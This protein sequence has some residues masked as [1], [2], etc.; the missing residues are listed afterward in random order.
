MTD[1]L[2]NDQILIRKLTG[3]VCENLWNE[4]FGVKELVKESGLSRYSLT[5]RLHVIAQKTINQFIRETRLHKALEMLQKEEVTVAE[6]AYK[7]GFGSPTYFNKCFHEFFGYPPGMAKKADPGPGGESNHIQVVAGQIHKRNDRQSLFII[8]ASILC[9]TILVYLGSNSVIFKRSTSNAGIPIQYP[10]KSLAVLP[11]KN[12]SDSTANQYFIDGVMEEILTNLCKIHDIKVI[13]RTSVEEFR[14]SPKSASEIAKKL[15]VDYIVEG[16]GQKYGN[17]FRFRVQLIEVP[18]DRHIWADAYEFEMIETKSLFKIQSQIAQKIATALEA[19]I[20]SK[21]KDLIEKVPTQSMVAYKLYQK[22][23]NYE[24]DYEKTRNLSSYQTAVNLYNAALELDT[25]FARAYTGLA[26]AFWSRYYAETYFKEGFLDSCQI[27]AEKALSIDEKLD[28]AYYVKGRYFSEKGEIAE[29]LKNYDKALEINP[30]YSLAYNYKGTILAFISNDYVKGLDNFHKA[31]DLT[32]GDDRISM[33]NYLVNLY[34]NCGFWEKAKYYLDEATNLSG[35]SARFFLNSGWMEFCQENFEGALKLFESAGKIDSV[36]FADQFLYNIPPG[37]LEEAY[38]N[39]IRKL[40]S[41][42]R[43]GK[44]NLELCHIGYTLWQ[45]GKYEEADLC[46]NQHIKNCEDIIR[47]NRQGGQKKFA[48][49]DLA[50]IYAFKGDKAK[51]F[52][53]LEEYCN[54]SYSR[55][56][57]LSLTKNDPMF[58]NIRG[59][60]R[61]KNLVKKMETNYQAEHERVQKWL[62][63]QEML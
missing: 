5:R 7:V 21:V 19:T 35:D 15:N 11:F 22:A 34:V 37:H 33:L 32:R 63:K 62:V 59:D 57:E 24:R 36:I 2:S 39:A 20:T 54:R 16:S 52:K 27:L 42:E 53:Y 3:I 23:N 41:Y 12:F 1:P 40:E 26:L 55:P 50:C 44:I 46:F 10:K 38:T 4:N 28:E 8:S 61:F 56:I 6:I 25:V 51:A 43:S 9:L 47:L 13:S 14:E 30:N 60:D 31:L 48:H 58:A 45:A 18:T 49:Y 29:A 17:T